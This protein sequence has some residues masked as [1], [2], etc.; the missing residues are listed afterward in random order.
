MV[1][2]RDY[3]KNLHQYFPNI[4]WKAILKQNM[5]TTAHEVSVLFPAPTI[6]SCEY[7]GPQLGTTAVPS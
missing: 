2:L 4:C 6:C 7:M 5:Q 3:L 1:K